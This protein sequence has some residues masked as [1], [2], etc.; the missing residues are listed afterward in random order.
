LTR[1]A[2]QPF[3]DAPFWFG[4]LIGKP[5]VK[6]AW[7][8]AGEADLTSGRQNGLL[9]QASNL[10]NRLAFGAGENVAHAIEYGWC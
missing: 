8:K 1:L 6:F 5:V 10:V 4:T 9:P 7:R 3:V 2:A